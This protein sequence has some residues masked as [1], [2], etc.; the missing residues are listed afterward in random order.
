M[1]LVIRNEETFL[2]MFVYFCSQTQ[3]LSVKRQISF[4]WDKRVPKVCFRW[5]NWIKAR[6]LFIYLGKKLS[7]LTHVCLFVFFFK[8]RRQKIWNFKLKKL[9]IIFSLSLTLS[10]SLYL[11]IQIQYCLYLFILKSSW[12]TTFEISWE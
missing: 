7:Q 8:Q 1:L 6:N 11:S 12:I 4:K 9:F 10:L 2:K 5:Y 3:Y